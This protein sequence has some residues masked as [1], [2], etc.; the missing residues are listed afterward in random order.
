MARH[1]DHADAAWQHYFTERPTTPSKPKHIR[2][3]LRGREFVFE[4]DKSVFA[5]DYVDL[6]T[7]RL[8]EVAHLPD[9]GEVLD[10]G[11]GYGAIG[12]AIAATHPRLRVWMVDINERAVALARRNLKRNRIKNAIALKSDGTAA[13]PPDLQFDAI[14]TNP[15]IHAGKKVLVRLICEAF[16]R[17]KVGGTFWF[18]ARTQHGAKTLQRLTA[19]IFGDAE[20]VDIHGGYR[21]IVAVKERPAPAPDAAQ[22][23]DETM[24][25]G[26]R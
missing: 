20:C 21:V 18:V 2:A 25:R 14:L 8:V 16:E 1:N 24:Q 19:E 9:E 5:K 22:T 10:L 13:L 26:E 23:D 3:R 6:G 12:I 7:K 4:T 15:P 11:C 17:L